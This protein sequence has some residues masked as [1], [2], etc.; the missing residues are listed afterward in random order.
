MF[1]A[2]VIGTSDFARDGFIQLFCDDENDIPYIK[3][4]NSF[5]IDDKTYV[6]PQQYDM[7]MVCN[8]VATG[9]SIDET[10]DNLTE[11]IAKIKCHQLSID[12]DILKEA[13][14][15]FNSL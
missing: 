2:E 3:Q 15:G 5:M 4:P 9:N 6:I 11:R 8:V 12:V 1:G 13:I 14:E 7:N 10:I